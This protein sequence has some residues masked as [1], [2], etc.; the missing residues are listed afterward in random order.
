MANVPLFGTGWIRSTADFSKWRSKIFLGKGLDRQIGDLPVGQSA[1]MFAAVLRAKAEGI[2][3]SLSSANAD[4][5][6]LIRLLSA[7]G[8]KSFSC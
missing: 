2:T 3:A 5:A 4:Y 1:D 8:I 7:F 6:S